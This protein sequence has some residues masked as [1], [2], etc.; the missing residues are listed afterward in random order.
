MKT[1]SSVSLSCDEEVL[2]VSVRSS[3]DVTAGTSG[4]SAL[5]PAAVGFAGAFLNAITAR[6]N[7]YSYVTNIA[8]RWPGLRTTGTRSYL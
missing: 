8:G 4:V 1:M 3:G 6:P 7:G 2:R 5:C